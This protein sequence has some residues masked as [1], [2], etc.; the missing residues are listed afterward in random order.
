MVEES[1]LPDDPNIA[2]KV[3][4]ARARESGL[5]GKLF[6]TREHAPTNIAALALLLLF[7]A[8]ILL[9]SIPHQEGANKVGY[10]TALISSITFIVG[11]L[12]GRKVE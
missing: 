12:F 10:T 3:I 7:V 5:L 6:G 4:D 2:A 8:L 9:L 11:L 1:K